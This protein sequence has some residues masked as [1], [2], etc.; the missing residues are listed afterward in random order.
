MK[1]RSSNEKTVNERCW[2]FTRT[3]KKTSF[4]TMLAERGGL[5]M[6]DHQYENGQMS[7]QGKSHRGSRQSAEKAQ[8]VNTIILLVLF[9]RLVKEMTRL[10]VAIQLQGGKLQLLRHST[11]KVGEWNKNKRLLCKR[12]WQTFEEKKRQKHNDCCGVFKITIHELC[13]LDQSSNYTLKVASLHLHS[14]S[15]LVLVLNYG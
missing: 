4:E 6:T 13:A 2:Y 3:T 10:W 8:Q 14:Q 15:S 7:L 11:L 12:N 1:Q 5:I 9:T